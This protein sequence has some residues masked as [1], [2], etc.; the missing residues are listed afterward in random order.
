MFSFTN[1]GSASPVKKKGSAEEDFAPAAA[2]D[3]SASFLAKS[4][5]PLSP[6]FSKSA[7]S[8]SAF[9]IAPFLLFFFLSPSSKDYL[10]NLLLRGV[11]HS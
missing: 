7:A 6:S 9:E 1:L 5:M 4:P 2:A 8:F 11:L 10:I 3:F